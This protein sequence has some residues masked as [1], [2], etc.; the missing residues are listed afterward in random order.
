MKL[1]SDMPCGRCAAGT[2]ACGAIEEGLR[3]F[4]AYP[5]KRDAL[6][7]A[8]KC[9]VDTHRICVGAKHFI[10]SMTFPIDA[11]KVRLEMYG[12]DDDKVVAG[13][14]AAPQTSVAI[15]ESPTK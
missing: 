6:R 1:E 13:H 4:G 15:M 7:S 5:T 2:Y 9:K 12:T 14:A 3:M 8:P 10:Q 11:A